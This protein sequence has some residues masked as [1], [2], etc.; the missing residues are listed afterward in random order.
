MISSSPAAGEQVA[1]NTPVALVVSKGMVAVPDVTGMSKEAAEKALQ[2]AGF[3]MQSSG[4]N[5]FGTGKVNGQSPA[6]GE[7]KPQRT[8]VTVTFPFF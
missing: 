5:L 2:A 4:V 1:E 8:V 3:A 6:A 7:R